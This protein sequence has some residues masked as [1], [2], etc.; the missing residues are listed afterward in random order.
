[1]DRFGY[2]G[3]LDLWRS[4]TSAPFARADARFLSE[5]SAPVTTAL[6]RSQAA[7]FT[8]PGTANEHRRGPV[9]LLLGPDLHVHAQT[10]ETEDYLR[11]LVPPDQDR[12]PIPAGAYNVA[13]QLLAVEAGIDAHPPSARVHL[14]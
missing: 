2:W 6:R 11:Q 14:S 10:P 5:I 9:V 1:K 13:A 7:T 12:S 3:F 4:G 8:N